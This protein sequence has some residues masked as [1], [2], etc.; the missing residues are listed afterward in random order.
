MRTISGH[1]CDRRI[2]KYG[3]G[4]LVALM[5]VMAAAAVAACWWYEHHG[6]EDETSSKEEQE[7]TKEV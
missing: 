1:N 4:Y 2:I 7:K 3:T 6:R 5:G